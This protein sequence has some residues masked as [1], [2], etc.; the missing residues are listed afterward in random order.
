MFRK[1]FG[2]KTEKLKEVEV[3]DVKEE[4]ERE[5]EEAGIE[6]TTSEVEAEGANQCA[7]PSQTKLEERNTIK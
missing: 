3:K 2:E 7:T 4:I 6:P 5:S 1:G